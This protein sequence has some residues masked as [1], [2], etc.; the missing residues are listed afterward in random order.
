M[1]RKLR[2]FDTTLRDGEQAP[3]IHLI[4][5]KKV[6]IARALD[7]AGVDVIEAGFP[8]NGESERNA[9]RM[10]SKEVENSEVAVL[11]RPIKSE[12]DM[13][14]GVLYRAGRS[15]LH[16]WV[17]TSPIHMRDKLRMEPL[18]VINK[19]INA[20]RYAKGRFD[21]IQFSSE[22]ATRSDLFFLGNI[23]KEGVRAGADVVNLA[24]TVG[25]AM[26][27]HISLMI[28]HVRSCVGDRVPVG[29]HC[30]NDLGLA[31]ANTLSAV[32]AGAGQIDCTVTGIGERAGNCS[33][34]QIAVILKFNIRHL[35]VETNMRMDRL[36][37][38]CDT[39]KNDMGLNIQ[40][41]QPLIGENAF[42]H[43]SGIHVHGVLKNPLTYEI[44]DPE[45]MGLH[46]GQFVIGKHTGKAALRHFLEKNNLTL[47]DENL[48]KLTDLVKETTTYKGPFNTEQDLIQFARANGFELQ[49][50]RRQ[51]Q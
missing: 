24:D 23:M 16:L 40:I 28:Q 18:D 11:C 32:R 5:E 25:C 7:S 14:E 49:P 42:K 2:V 47:D 3:G 38:L 27:E 48:I 39:V 51:C 20:I 43:E 41:W 36:G 9:I 30:H 37:H 50:L 15:R 34:E 31:T 21:S 10:I 29:I 8:A 26:P 46:K 6:S 33:L 4:P 45:Q 35:G 17:S 13:C 19:M 44:I 12:I 22:D 1:V